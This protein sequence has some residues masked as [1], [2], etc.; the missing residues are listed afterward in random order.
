MNDK[1]EE[2]KGTVS[3]YN[4]QPVT[5]KKHYYS[6]SDES[7]EQKD[8][9]DTLFNIKSFNNQLKKELSKE[10]TAKLEIEEPDAKK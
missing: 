1:K 2:L 4:K 6:V 9:D 3:Q 10:N 5:L 7:K 8:F